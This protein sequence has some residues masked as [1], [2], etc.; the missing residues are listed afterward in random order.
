MSVFNDP[1]SIVPPMKNVVGNTYA[2]RRAD[3][4]MARHAAEAA[5]AA[6]LAAFAEADAAK[7]ANKWFL[8]LSVIF[9]VI[10]VS[11]AGF[12]I[13]EYLSNSKLREEN[14]TLSTRNTDLLNEV[15]TLTDENASLSTEL[16]ALKEKS[17]KSETEAKTETDKADKSND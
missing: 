10:A 3:A 17:E 11:G 4:D 13:Y 12:G 15:E 6:R 5:E 7:K 14:A 9:A 1:K 16:E 8:V 2:E